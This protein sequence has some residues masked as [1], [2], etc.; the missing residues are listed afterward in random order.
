MTDVNNAQSQLNEVIDQT[1]IEPNDYFAALKSKVEAN[2]DSSL[3]KQYQILIK[4]IEDASAIGQQALVDSLLFNI[5]VIDK[6]IKLLDTPFTKFVRM[7][8]LKELVDKVQPK[9]SIKIIELE[10]YPRII[11]EDV[12]EKIQAAKGLGVFDKYCVVFTDLTDND[13]KTP[14]EKKFV[15]RNRDPIVF[16]YFSDLKLKK[17]H[18]KFYLI[19]DWEDEWCDLTFT[20]AVEKMS[21]LN[22]ADSNGELK[23]VEEIVKMYAVPDE[24]VD[25]DAGLSFFARMKN[26]MKS[27]VQ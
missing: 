15:E 13:Y 18:E 7:E 6:E 9:N 1:P 21:A 20:K 25:A 11:P 16:G 24:E 8:A 12:K 5:A 27:L 23:T 3:S 2:A 22:I 26:R 4:E 17:N 14:E 19:G 10:R